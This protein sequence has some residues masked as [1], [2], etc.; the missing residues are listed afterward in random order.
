MEEQSTQPSFEELLEQSERGTLTKVQTGKK[1]AGTVVAVSKARVYIDIGMRTEA[2]LPVEGEDPRISEL[3][4]GDSLDVYI[5]N[6]SGQVRVAL[7][8]ILGYGDFSALE[9]AYEKDQS[10]E[11]KVTAVISG[12]Y[13]VNIAGVKCFCP[14]SQI[15]DRPVSDPRQMVGQ[16]FNF[17]IIRLEAQ[18]SNVVLSRRALQ[19]EKKQE[20]LEET[21]RMLAVGAVMTGTVR[22]LQPYGAFVDLGGI[23]GLLHVS[24]ISHTNVERVE[25][26]LSPGQE[27]EVKILD[28]S[29][30]ANGKQRIS[31]STKALLPDPWENHGFHPGERITGTVARKSNFGI[32][33][34]AYDGFKYF[35]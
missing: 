31:L 12:G 7:D 33:I 29:V 4:E 28:L 16:T 14:H 3:K 1:I 21:R 9:D 20:Q 32:F 8:P 5:A 26:V 11:G 15:N 24:Q 13:D 35:K 6:P 22:D 19:E 23:Q 34:R 2:V 17:K 18:S 10:V 25:D 27:V 30:G